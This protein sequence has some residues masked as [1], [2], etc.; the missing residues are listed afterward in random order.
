M[1]DY[2]KDICYMR[3]FIPRVTSLANM[4]SIVF[5]HILLYQR[6]FFYFFAL[7]HTSLSKFWKQLTFTLNEYREYKHSDKLLK[8]NKEKNEFFFAF[9]EN[10]TGNRVF[11]K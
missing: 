4:L 10:T 5:N 2:M 1:K 11:L 6:L 7:P 9:C 8:R 3:R